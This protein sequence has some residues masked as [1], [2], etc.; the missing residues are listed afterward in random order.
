MSNY[1]V[2]G[3]D[4]TSVANAIRTKSGG[5]SQL[6]FPAGFVSEIQA[7]PSG[8]SSVPDFTLVGTQTI[9]ES[10]SQVTFSIPASTTQLLIVVSSAI[11]ASRNSWYYWYFNNNL[12][13]YYRNSNRSSP[14]L[15]PCSAIYG[16]MVETG[17]QS[18]VSEITIAGVS[19]DRL[20]SVTA[21]NL[22]AGGTLKLTGYYSDSRLTGGTI[23]VYWR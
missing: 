1:L 12:I 19:T 7:I 8:G 15:S 11:T 16:K 10:V 23:S 17:G 4:L 2:D 14:S 22:S 18:D 3:A 6:A 13:F 21:R 9:T 5:S 20:E